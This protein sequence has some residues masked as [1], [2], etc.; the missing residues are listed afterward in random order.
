MPGRSAARD[1]ENCGD[2]LFAQIGRFLVRHRL[3]PDPGHYAFAFHVL[4][5]PLGPLGQAVAALSDG[6]VRLSRADIESLGGEVS[7]DRPPLSAAPTAPDD[8][9]ELAALAAREVAAFADMVRAIRDETRGFGRDLAAGAEAI[10][11][12]GDLPGIDEIKLLIA[13][14]LSRVHSAEARL[15]TATQEAAE[16]R[17]NLAEAQGSARR[18]PLTELANRRALEEAFAVRD[19]T[20]PMAIAICDVD[21]FKQVNDAFGHAVGDRVL[22][23]IGQ[24]LAAACEGHLVARYGGEEFAVLFAA[25]ALADAAATLDAARATIAGRRFR[26]RESGMEIGTITLSAGLSRVAS[27]D[28]L[29]EVIA[30]A[31]RA[32]YRAKEDG[33]D[34]IRLADDVP[35]NGAIH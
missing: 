26:L 33:R 10:R 28:P 5:D 18:D 14:M 25:T 11:R 12:S 2:A 17:H 22:R 15:A 4:S 31:D 34:R 21:H 19:P 23:A 16:L 20:Q 6:G 9:G 13:A 32:L 35:K 1:D 29:D 30:R 3:S 8:G 24:A 27:D 7:I